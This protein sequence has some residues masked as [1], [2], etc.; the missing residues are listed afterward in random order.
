MSDKTLAVQGKALYGQPVKDAQHTLRLPESLMDRVDEY[1]AQ[2][3]GEIKRSAALRLLIL[4][5][6]DAE[7]ACATNQNNQA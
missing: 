1:R 4:R 5:G 2:Y 3:G 7:G 6:L